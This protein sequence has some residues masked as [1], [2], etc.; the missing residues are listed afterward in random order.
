MNI[1]CISVSSPQ[2]STGG[3]ER[4]ITNLIHFYKDKK[5]SFLFLILPTT[6]EDRIEIVGNVTIYHDTSLVTPRTT[7]QHQQIS[8]QAKK[9]A[10]LMERIIKEKNIQIIC[11]DN[12]MFGLPALFSLLLNMVAAIHKTP[13]VLHLHSFPATELQVELINQLMWNKIS[14][15]SQS[16]AGD[17]FQK[18]TSV[19]I[20]E[21]HYL[22]VNTSQF[23]NEKSTSTGFK[24]EL[25]LSADSKIILSASRIIR[26][27]HNILHE[28]GLINVI[29]AFSK[30]Y[31]RHP[32]FYLVI[33]VGSSSLVLKN[34]FDASYEMLLG[35]IKLHGIQ[36][37]TIVKIIK[38]EDMPRAYKESDLFVLASE[39]E[40][41]GQV[42][43]EAMSCAVPVI[44][45]K[46]GGIPE[47]ISDSYNGYLVQ[48][49]DASILAQKMEKLINDKI[50]REKFTKA[51]LKTV[52]NMFT[53]ENQFVSF[54]KMMEET[55]NTKSD[56]EM[57]SI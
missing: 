52:K 53:A 35:Y 55:I 22:G 3:V 30:I 9:F 34:E 24:K 10:A 47:I 41:F 17:C 6:K 33:A 29:K 11:A 4:Y 54:H 21:T 2:E 28:K 26:G 51:G 23:N 12:I 5:D 16:V 49:N 37:Q 32:N 18:G 45:T 43:I 46:V 42:F 1:L 31:A 15:V 13:I 36:N 48:P 44:G 7:L 57:F 14:C 8:I 25:G 56:F 50:T 40:T 27:K 20:L 19:D 38:L 39:N